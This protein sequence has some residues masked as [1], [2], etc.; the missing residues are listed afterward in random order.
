MLKVIQVYTVTQTATETS[1]EIKATFS[2]KSK[3]EN[4]QNI[5][6]RFN[7]STEVEKIKKTIEI[8]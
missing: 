7:V 3:A 2:T 1:E 8:D 6:K 5:L 4:A